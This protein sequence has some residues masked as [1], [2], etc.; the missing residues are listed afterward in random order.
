MEFS[1]PFSTPRLFWENAKPNGNVSGS[2]CGLFNASQDAKAISMSPAS[3]MRDSY[4]FQLATNQ[5][6]ICT[7]STSYRE[8]LLHTLTTPWV[9]DEIAILYL[10]RDIQDK[11]MTCLSH[12]L[13]QHNLNWRLLQQPKSQSASP[14]PSLPSPFLDIG[15]K[16]GLDFFVCEAISAFFRKTAPGDGYGRCWKRGPWNTENKQIIS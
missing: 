10:I 3:K 9:A 1:N 11:T 7:C 5:S 6:S 12:L 8:V 13:K 14:S 16:G 15:A 2:T 4:S